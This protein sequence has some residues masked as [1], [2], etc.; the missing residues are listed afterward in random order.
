MGGDGTFQALANTAFGAGVF[1]GVLPVG[2]GNDFAASLGLPDDPL[3]AAD[4]ILRGE[5]RF[6]DLLR[7]RTDEGRI[8]LYAGGGGIGLDA[9]AARYASGT[10]RRFP[11]RSRY[12]ASALR[13][14]VGFVPFE[15]RV[16][17]PGTDLI[18]EE[19]KALV[20]ARAENP[21]LRCWSQTGSGCDP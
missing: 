15:V 14:L 20:V 10:Y 2:G 19:A 11:G 9:Q 12:I 5:P 3:K 4:A 6:V 7:V 13:A 1:L 18:P 17:F 21:D 8:R 16:D